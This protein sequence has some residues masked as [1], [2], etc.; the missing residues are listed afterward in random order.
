MKA[1]FEKGTKICSSCKQELPIG[2]FYKN[3]ST[4]DG[5]HSEC[6]Q[7]KKKYMQRYWQEHTGKIKKRKKHQ[8]RY[9]GEPHVRYLQYRQSAKKRSIKF[10]LTEEEFCSIAYTPCVYCG[11]IQESG[12][13]LDR[14][15]SSK[16]YSIDNCVSCC[17]VCNYAKH[18]QSKE[19]FKNSI[20]SRW[21]M[22]IY[23]ASAVIRN[24]AI[25]I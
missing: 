15:D 16:G 18:V 24:H 8:K 20:N 22:S 10:N 23:N 14:V 4:E 6:R 17:K 7:C 9:R 2:E 13:G 25:P 1:D 11:E 21:E 19:E 12:N 3:K 5:L